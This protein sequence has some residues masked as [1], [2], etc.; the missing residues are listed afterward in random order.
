MELFS[1]PAATALF[2][3]MLAFSVLSAATRPPY[4]YI[5][6]AAVA[7]TSAIC[8]IFML[9][10]GISLR[11]AALIYMA[12]LFVWALSYTVAS[13]IRAR[14]AA[15]G[16]G[17]DS[18][19]SVGASGNIAKDPD[20]APRDIATEPGEDAEKPHSGAAD[21]AFPDTSDKNPEVAK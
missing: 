21:P 13:H 9:H 2:A 15:A 4:S 12:S 14:R 7:L 5:S 1:S 20:T 18:A 6:G 3:L 10:D 8:A 16:Q 19:A 17:D 11:T